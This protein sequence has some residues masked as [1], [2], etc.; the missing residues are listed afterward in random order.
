GAAT[1]TA[2]V[3]TNQRKTKCCIQRSYRNFWFRQTQ[4]RNN[5]PILRCAVNE[6]KSSTPINLCRKRT[7]LSKAKLEV[8]RP[9]PAD[10]LSELNPKKRRLAC[11]QRGKPLNRLARK[12]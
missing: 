2:N 5:L 11:R 8:D 7:K 6:L 9:K 1:N 12:V 10:H 4:A 3:V